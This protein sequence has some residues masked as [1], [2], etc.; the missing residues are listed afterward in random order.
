MSQVPPRTTPTPM[1]EMPAPPTASL[2]T[3]A[4]YKKTFR[5]RK[6]VSKFVDPC[7]EARKASLLCLEKTHYNRSECFDFFTAYK[8]CKS[9]W[10]AQRRED[11]VKG[12]DFE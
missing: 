10:M 7:E 1:H 5:D 11:R 2:E 3:P 6:T 4:D 8:N 9:N 12:R